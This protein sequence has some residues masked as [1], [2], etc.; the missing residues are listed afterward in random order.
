MFKK[1]WQN[2][3]LLLAA[4]LLARLYAVVQP[5]QPYDIGTYQAW[6]KL[7]PTHG[8]AA[9]FATTWADYLPLPIYLFS[10]LDKLAATLGFDFAFVF[11]SFFSFLELGLLTWLFFLHRNSRS[12]FFLFAFF[13]LLLSPALIGDT[14]WWGQTDSLPALLGAISLTHFLKYLPSH[15]SKFLLLASSLLALAIS[16]KPILILT[17][18]VY[19][20]LFL[21]NSQR[22]RDWLPVLYSSLFA[23]LI[24]VLPALP[25]THGNPLT[26]FQFLLDKTLEQAATYPFT[27]VNAFNLYNLSSS[28]S[29]W[30]SDSIVVLGFSA[31]TLGQVLFGALALLT[32]NS[33]RRHKFA[34]Q[35]AYRVA[36][37]ILIL[38]YAFTTR[39]HER[40]LLFGLPFLALASLWQPFLLFLFTV[41]TL[42]F[43]FNLWA[44]YYWVLHA[45]TW[46]MATFWGNLTSW[47]T[48]LTTLALT[49]VWDWP[50]ALTKLKR[51]LFSHSRLVLVLLLAFA[52]RLILLN[53]PPLHIFDE[54]YHAFTAEELVKNNPAAWEWWNTPPEGF[55]Y[56]WTHPPLAKY[57]MVAGLLLFGD[58]AFGWRFFSVLMGVVSIYGLY[59]FTLALKLPRTTALTA[60]FLLTISGLHLVQ[61]RIGMNDI[62]LLAFLIWSMER[63]LVG[64]YKSAAILFGLAL[65]SKWSAL[66]A[67]APLALIYLK[68]NLVP[69]H[70]IRHTVY[71][72][73]HTARLLII[74]TLTYTLSYT[75][76]FLSGHSIQQFVELHRQMWYY[77]T[78][79][80]A[81]H[82]YQ[83]APW[84][85]TLSLRPVWYWVEY[86]ERAVSHIYVQGNPALLWLGLVALIMLLPKIRRFPYL[87]LYTTYLIL[88]IPWLFSPRIMFFYHYLP[89]AAFLMVILA[90]WLTTLS[91]RTRRLLTLLFVLCFLL[92]SPMYYGYPMPSIYW[93]SLFG[94]FPSW[95]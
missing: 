91:T 50:A 10:L 76:F 18:P 32:L 44:A 60:A 66:Y 23:L 69:P 37:T 47:L 4:A 52:L 22:P 39:M 33:W 16:F 15:N 51:I 9:F 75:P 74:V 3:W 58:H 19:L 94:I 92:L 89:S 86:K 79:L 68:N 49:L 30:P 41:F 2:N 29:T 25:V 14:S 88:V 7:L 13:F 20:I 6:A 71:H 26:A 62:Y 46:P 85:W 38:F 95:K 55:A 57:G 78:H 63:A 54:V 35:Y 28:L 45:Q 43:T 59:R 65:A 11:K 36:A 27:S 87:V 48:V 70:S 21:T 24:F 61:S 64:R 17:L 12:R 77:H 93:D 73:L 34:P 83:S 80:V 84:Q 53:H 72:L 31:R 67:L 81:T 56:E 8:P 40:H 5:A 90:A 1:I 42:L 82:T